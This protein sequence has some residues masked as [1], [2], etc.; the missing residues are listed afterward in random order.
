[1]ADGYLFHE[2]FITNIEKIYDKSLGYD[3]LD[4]EADIQDYVDHVRFGY[5]DSF[6][7]KNHTGIIIYINQTSSSDRGLE[8]IRR[9][10]IQMQTSIKLLVVPLYCSV[11]LPPHEIEPLSH[12]AFNI[13]IDNLATYFTFDDHV[14]EE[15][16]S[17]DEVPTLIPVNTLLETDFTDTDAS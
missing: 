15:D 3:C 14:S 16:S 17:E 5:W 1:V 12:E 9:K 10:I 11:L 2:K 6:P 4:V 13:F 7:E 8:L